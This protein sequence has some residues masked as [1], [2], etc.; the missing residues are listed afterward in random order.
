MNVVVTLVVIAVAAAWAVAVYRRLL[1]LRALVTGAW[2]RLEVDQSNDAIK[3]VYN[4]HVAKYNDAL[5]G[6][7]G[8]IVA[9]L[10]GLKPARRFD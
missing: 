4:K 8:N 10:A 3:T 6:F 1:A 9:M 2:K 7:P 5:A